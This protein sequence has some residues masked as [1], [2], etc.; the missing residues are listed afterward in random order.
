VT[1]FNKFGSLKIEVRSERVVLGWTYC[2]DC[3][4]HLGHAHEHGKT[5]PAESSDSELVVYIAQF[6]LGVKDAD[7]IEF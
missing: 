2:A 3:F 7:V 6:C 1:L 4:C 5:S